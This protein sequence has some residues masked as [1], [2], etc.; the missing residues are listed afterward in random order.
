MRPLLKGKEAPCNCVFRAVFRTCYNR[1]RDCVARGAYSGTVSLEFCRGKDGRRT[2]S[3]KREDFMADFCLVSQRL[4]DEADHRVFRAHFI[5]GANWKLCCRQLNMDRGSFFHAVYR[6]E[7]QLGR[8][9]AEI[10]PYPLFPL[11]EYFSGMLRRPPA[12]TATT[13]LRPRLR[14]SA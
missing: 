9:F 14:L 6:I 5:L 8:A 10:E 11:D 3:R 12:G 13:A 4:L 7:Q 2:Y 1:F